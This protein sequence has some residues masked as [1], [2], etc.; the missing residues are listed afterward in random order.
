MKRRIEFNRFAKVEH[1]V[2]AGGV[3]SA[4]LKT[5]ISEK[6]KMLEVVELVNVG[7]TVHWVSDGAWSMHTLLM[8]L[9]QKFGAAE[10]YISSYAM[11]ETPARIL[12]RLKH[13]GVITKLH[14]VLDNRV[15][16]RTAGSLQLI[17]G[18]ADRY[19]LIDT[20][21]K[22]TLIKNDDVSIVVAG[23]ANYTENERYEAG[24]ITMNETA[25]SLHYKWMNDELDRNNR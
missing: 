14:C 17:K 10:V 16:V 1:A 18:I 11:G 13:D 6:E 22:V 7:N 4:D 5:L 8:G 3:L 20:H 2:L 25:F 19:A 9:L 12:A 24:V 21:A 23:S 15:D